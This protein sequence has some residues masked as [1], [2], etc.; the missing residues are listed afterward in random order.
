[1]STER[2]CPYCH[3]SISKRSAKFHI[4]GCRKRG[5]VK[6]RGRPYVAEAFSIINR[7]NLAEIA[8]AE[9]RPKVKLDRIRAIPDE[10]DIPEATY[11]EVFHH[12]TV[13][14][15]VI[16]EMGSPGKDRI[17]NYSTV[18]GLLEFPVRGRWIIS[19][20]KFIDEFPSLFVEIE[21]AKTLNTTF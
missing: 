6:L 16:L 12:C 8:I 19:K 5:I 18:E 11:D 4:H 2:T 15:R 13:G 1:M 20:D 10:T 21:K 7:G 17:L 9:G 14:E 3:R